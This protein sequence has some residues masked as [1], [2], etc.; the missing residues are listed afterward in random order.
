[1]RRVYKEQAG[2]LRF[3]RSRLRVILVDDQT[4]LRR[5]LRALLDAEPDLEVIGEADSVLEALAL[6]RRLLPDVV[7]ADVTFPNSDGFQAISR[8]RRECA[9]VRVLLLSPHSCPECTR[10]AMTSGAHAY[11]VKASPFDVLLRAVRSEGPEFDRA[12]LPVN[13][14]PKQR[15]PTEQS[16][17]AQVADMTERERQ[18]LIGVALGY[19][20]KRIAG[21]LG[22]SVKIIEKLRSKMM[23]RLGLNNAAA[24]TRFALD[25]GLLRFGDEAHEAGPEH[26][27]AA[28]GSTPE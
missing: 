9:G 1:M 12:A 14:L 4:I 27:S 11:I 3:R 2:Q 15:R 23:H 25:N 19:S 16:V 8:L 17:K 21:D 20:N 10:A 22:R 13:A 26:G 7:I 28:A 5:G 6:S 18:V 24:A